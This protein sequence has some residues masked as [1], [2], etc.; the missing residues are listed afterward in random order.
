M[1]SN[2]NFLQ[3]RTEGPF[4]DLPSDP[5]Q[6]LQNTYPIES[7]IGLRVQEIKTKIV[8]MCTRWLQHDPSHGERQF[9]TIHLSSK[10]C[11][12]ILYRIA[13]L[14]AQNNA[15][16]E[17]GFGMRMAD[18]I[19]ASFYLVSGTTDQLRG[20]VRSIKEDQEKRTIHGDRVTVGSLHDLSIIVPDQ[21]GILRD[22]A[23]IL[24]DRGINIKTQTLKIHSPAWRALGYP[25]R[26]GQAEYRSI[27]S[28]NLR[29]EIP[30]QQQEVAAIIIDEIKGIAPKKEWDIEM[31]HLKD[32]HR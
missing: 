3:I 6:S 17:E 9:L 23:R 26:E 22:I 13:D 10:D 18:A 2:P 25:D 4:V 31:T 27:A 14:I 15:N 8:P 24:R 28:I 20:V 30:A 29:I 1:L 5:N 11:T 12:G 7:D 19:H 21:I 16:I 32:I